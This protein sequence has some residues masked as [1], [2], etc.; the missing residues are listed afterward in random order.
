MKTHTRDGPISCIFWLYNQLIFR[1][2]ISACQ[3][4]KHSVGSR[5]LR[6]STISVVLY[7]CLSFRMSFWLSLS[8]TTRLPLRGFSSNFVFVYYF[9]SKIC[10]EISIITGTLYDGP[11]QY[12]AGFLLEWEDASHKICRENQNT[13]FT[14]NNF[15]PPTSPLENRGVCEIMWKN[16][17]DPD[18]PQVAI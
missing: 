9:F 18:R 13:H 1:P 2:H 3:L 16:I 5:K 15:P 14:F 6:K 11:W 8:G 7:V 4:S 17:I 10:L 12:L